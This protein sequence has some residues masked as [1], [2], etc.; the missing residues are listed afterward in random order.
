[1]SYFNFNKFDLSYRFLAKTINMNMNKML[2]QKSY[3]F[4]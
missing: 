1:M 2:F 3:N 4:Y